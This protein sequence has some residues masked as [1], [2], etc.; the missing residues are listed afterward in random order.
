MY[1]FERSL[2]RSARATDQAGVFTIATPRPLCLTVGLLRPAVYVSTGLLEQLT[3]SDLEI[4]LEHEAAHVRRRDTVCSGI[5]T[6]LYVVLP[7][8]GHRLLLGDWRIAVERTCDREAARRTG[9]PLDVAET[10]VRVARLVTWAPAPLPNSACFAGWGQD[11]EGRVASLLRTSS[12]ER[13][14]GWAVG[15]LTGLS[16]TLLLTAALWLPHA[17]DLFAH[18]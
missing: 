18:H 12:D 7:V 2:R 6:L 15:T 13:P 3:G 5:L 9:D 10:L 1:A 17:V 11:L 8:P 16:V 4:V 14:N